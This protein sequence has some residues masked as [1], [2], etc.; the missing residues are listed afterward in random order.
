MNSQNSQNS[1]SPS[2]TIVI[3]E[4]DQSKQQSDVN[5]FAPPRQAQPTRQESAGNATSH[6]FGKLPQFELLLKS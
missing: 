3:S 4:N 5:R 1:G 6:G 2:K